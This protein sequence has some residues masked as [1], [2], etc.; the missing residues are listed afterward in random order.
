[1]VENFNYNLIK[2]NDSLLLAVS[3]GIDSMVL[4]AIVNGLKNKLN[5]Q[6]YIAHVDH[7]MR[8][9]SKDDRDFVKDMGENYDVEVF[10]D[11]LEAESN[12][13]FHDYAHYARYDFF[14]NIAKA[15]G[16]KKIVLAHNQ[17]DLAETVLM[18]LVRGSSFEGYRGILSEN[19]YKGIKIIRPMLNMSRADIEVYQQANLIPYRQD[20][21]N[22]KDDYTR[23]RF[24]HHLIPFLKEENPKFLDKITQFSYYQ[25]LAYELVEKEAKKFLNIDEIEDVFALDIEKFSKLDKIIQIE[26]IKI[27]INQITDNNLELTLNNLLDII[28]LTTS[29]KPHLSYN[30]SDQL[31]IEKS[32]GNLEFKTDR[33]IPFDYEFIV[34]DF[35]ELSLPDNHF[36]FI[37]KKPNKNYGFIDKLWYNNLDLIFPLTIRN[38]RNGDRLKFDFGTKKLKDFFID[39]KIKKNIRNNIPIICD[40]SG[41]IIFIPGL[42]KKEYKGNECLYIFYK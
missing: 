15:K 24:R 37:T 16:I 5:L 12:D 29:D 10:V 4:L 39:K 25:S 40:K 13:N 33:F 31:F 11:Y 1:M 18:R 23:N 27:I 36:L 38:R 19:H 32:Y 41:E 35:Q 34:D 30:I 7:Q 9:S 28:D 21:T 2:K 8:D 26:V 42:Y 17:D 14:W 22:L 6:L 20:P 3:G